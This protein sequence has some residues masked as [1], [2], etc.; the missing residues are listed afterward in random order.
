MP[1]PLHG[2]RPAWLIVVSGAVGMLLARALLPG[3][4]W[5]SLWRVAVL[6]VALALVIAGLLALVRLGMLE[7]RHPRPSRREYLRATGALVVA[8]MLVVA[9]G[10]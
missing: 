1:D 7:R 9:A 8:F 4:A 10:S 2:A 5:S 6:P 3:V